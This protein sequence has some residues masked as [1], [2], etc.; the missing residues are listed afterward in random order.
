MKKLILASILSLFIGTEVFAAACVAGDTVKPPVVANLQALLIGASSVYIAFTTP[1]DPSGLT[2]HDVRISTAAFTARSFAA[3]PKA[4][5]IP[6]PSAS[7]TWVTVN[8]AVLP[9]TKYYMAMTSTDGCGN[10]SALSNLVTFTTPAV[11]PVPTTREVSISWGFDQYAMGS[12]PDGLADVIINYGFKSRNDPTFTGWEFSA[13]VGSVIE[14]KKMVLDR[15]KYFLE[16][17]AV[18]DYGSGPLNSG[19]SNQICINPDV[20]DCVDPLL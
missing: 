13:N 2:S 4:S 5:N 8:E 1:D 10:V 20:S 9:S 19:P 15:R 14:L 7:G 18:Y 17:V 6:A 3:Q 12:T 11:P 16:A